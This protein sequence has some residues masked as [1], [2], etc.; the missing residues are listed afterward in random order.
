MHLVASGVADMQDIDTAVT[1]GPGFRWSIIGPLETADFGGL[2]TW[3]RVMDNLCAE[4]DCA[5]SAPDVIN[6]LNR[7]GH[8]G[9][10]TGEGFYR[11]PSGDAIAGKIRSRDLDF[12]RLL[13]LR[14]LRK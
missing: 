1:A 14:A 13:K 8:L 6:S 7:Q 2:D 4:L 9:I 11:Y 10:K 12:I 5:Q 3:Q